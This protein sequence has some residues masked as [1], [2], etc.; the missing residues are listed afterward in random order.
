MNEKRSYILNLAK[1]SLNKDLEKAQKK[2][3]ST[4][5]KLYDM[6]M[7]NTSVR[8]RAMARAAL[9][10]YCESRDRM[11]S[12]IDEIDKWKGEF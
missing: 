6:D 11:Q 7:N 2:V 3:D 8:S 5:T 12:Y 10:T 9:E 1:Q 4:S